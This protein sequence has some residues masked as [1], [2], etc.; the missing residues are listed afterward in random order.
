[1]IVKHSRA[2]ALWDSERAVS[3]N[4]ASHI[5]SPLS[6][7]RSQQHHLP[8]SIPDHVD[9]C[10]DFIFHQFK[11]CIY[12][13][14]D[15]QRGDPILY[16]LEAYYPST[17]RYGLAGYHMQ[18]EEQDA[19]ENGRYLAVQQSHLPTPIPIRLMNVFGDNGTFPEIV[20]T[21]WATIQ[22]NYQIDRN[23]LF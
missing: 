20:L 5:P 10:A 12:T 6:H 7:G 8:C 16:A 18:H 9:N 14:V 11:I 23:I 1:M 21:G 17:V 13:Y 2:C 19:N 3:G 15:P 4:Y 22:R